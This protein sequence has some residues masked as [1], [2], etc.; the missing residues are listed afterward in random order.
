MVDGEDNERQI[1]RFNADIAPYGTTVVVIED[2]GTDASFAE[3]F[4]DL[5]SKRKEIEEW[6]EGVKKPLNDSLRRLN[7]KQNE[8]CNPLKDLEY[9]ITQARAAWLETKQKAADAADAEARKSADGGVVVLAPQPVKTV[10]TTAGDVTMR[11][12]K[13]WRL[14][15]DPMITA[16]YVTNHKL[17]LRG[18][19]PRLANVPDGAFELVSSVV[20]AMLTSGVMPAG[21]H[22]I[23]AYDE[24]VSQLKG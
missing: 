17:K 21:E 1:E 16:R 15:D 8:L 24:A 11:K 13:S 9:K 12:Q 2:D 19:D 23:E 3:F 14:T 4:A 7:A 18:D 22:S 20:N 5:R 10:V 6:F